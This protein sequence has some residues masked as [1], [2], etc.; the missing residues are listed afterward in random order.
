VDQQVRQRHPHAQ[1]ADPGDRER[2]ARVAGPA[3]RPGEDDI[4]A[5][6]GMANAT[7]RSTGTPP[8]SPAACS[9]AGQYSKNIC[10][11]ST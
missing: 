10:G 6:A 2:H 4:D 3:H 1:E 8:R 9:G 7:S 5:S 11:A